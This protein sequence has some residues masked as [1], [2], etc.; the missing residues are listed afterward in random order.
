MVIN[1]M[2]LYRRFKPVE[3]HDTA[4]WANIYKV[5]EPSRINIPDEFEVEN[6][7]DWVDS[8]QK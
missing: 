2:R 3:R 5:R 1:K 6:A 4:A 7:K 8:N